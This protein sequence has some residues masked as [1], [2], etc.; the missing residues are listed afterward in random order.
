MNSYEKYITFNN[1]ILIRDNGN[2]QKW[3]KHS[4][5]IVVLMYLLYIFKV[6]GKRI[7]LK[8]E[9]TIIDQQMKAKHYN[10]QF[11]NNK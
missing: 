7:K 6:T 11:W 8:I 3:L 10:V 5:L 4:N 2:K 1:V 9:R